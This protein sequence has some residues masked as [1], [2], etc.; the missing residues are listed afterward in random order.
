MMGDIINIDQNNNAWSV[1]FDSTEGK[2]SVY[3]QLN[4]NRYFDLDFGDYNGGSIVNVDSSYSFK[5][6]IIGNI[7]ENPELL[8]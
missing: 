4:S 6:E 5:P 8:K 2:Y 1:E 3:N 7:Y